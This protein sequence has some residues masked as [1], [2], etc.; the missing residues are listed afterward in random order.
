MLKNTANINLIFLCRAEVIK[1]EHPTRGDDTR[2]W[3]PPY[4]KPT[5]KSSDPNYHG[6]SA[7]YLS[8]R[9]KKKSQYFEI[10]ISPPNFAK[11]LLDDTSSE[12]KIGEQVRLTLKTN[13]VKTW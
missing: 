10:C 11:R 3:G 13:A 7:Y 5:T 4:A 8:V 1:I 2:A 6:E 12:S 9:G